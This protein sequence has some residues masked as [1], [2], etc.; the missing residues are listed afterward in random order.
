MDSVFE[1]GLPVL[2]TRL[3]QLRANKQLDKANDR[4]VTDIFAGFEF[5]YQPNAFQTNS[6]LFYPS[7]KSEPQKYIGT[8]AIMLMIYSP[9]IGFC[10]EVGK[11]PHNSHI[12]SIF[13]KEPLSAESIQWLR[14]IKKQKKVFLMTSSNADYAK[15]ILSQ[16]FVENG[17]TIDYWE[18]FDLCIG[19]AR[20]PYFFNMESQ[21]YSNKNDYPDQPVRE[22][23]SGRWYSQG[24]FF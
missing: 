22:L 10:P 3:N 5:N 13:K 15:F 9:F 6:G 12:I 20:K 24:K 8:V 1:S 23:Q 17:K 11:Y 19:D 4:I 7:I 21:F 16:I 18:F 2:L 14:E